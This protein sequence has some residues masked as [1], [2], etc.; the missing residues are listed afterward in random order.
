MGITPYCYLDSCEN[1]H[2]FTKKAMQHRE[3]LTPPPLSSTREAIRNISHQ[4]LRVVR[5]LPAAIVHNIVK[6]PYHLARVAIA[7]SQSKY[8]RKKAE[9]EVLNEILQSLALSL[10]AVL[11]IVIGLGLETHKTMERQ[12]RD[13][14]FHLYLTLARLL[15]A[16]GSWFA[17]SGTV[18]LV[19]QKRL[20]QGYY[21]G[22][23]QLHFE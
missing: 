22:L 16:Y 17:P 5:S 23:T 19:I 15:E 8:E 1:I 18:Y 13:R 3:M 21:S 7:L 14:G 12:I 2:R 11:R 10:Q 20:P 4:G 9:N 6:P